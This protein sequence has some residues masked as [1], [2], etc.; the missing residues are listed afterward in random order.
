MLKVSLKKVLLNFA[1]ALQWSEDMKNLFLKI[2]YF[3]QSIFWI[4]LY[5]FIIGIFVTFN[6]F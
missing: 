1:D 3:Y 2:G 4:F 5:F 6:L